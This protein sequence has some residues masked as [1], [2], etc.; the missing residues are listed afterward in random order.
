MTSWRILARNVVFFD[1]SERN[2]V[3][4]REAGMTAEVFASPGQV[5][6]LLARA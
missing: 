1:D 4:A 3:A 6:A 2:V 5:R